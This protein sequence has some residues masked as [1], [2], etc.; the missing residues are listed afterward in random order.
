M[1]SMINPVG[2]TGAVDVLC[3]IWGHICVCVPWCII[4]VVAYDNWLSRAGI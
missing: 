1:G 4:V 3:V 2:V